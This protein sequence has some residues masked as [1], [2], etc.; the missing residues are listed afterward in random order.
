MHIIHILTN[1]HTQTHTHIY[2]IRIDNSNVY[3]VFLFQTSIS[4]MDV[5]A[6]CLTTSQ[7][8]LQRT[9]T[10]KPADQNKT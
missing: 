2:S 5:A 1:I 9:Y 4:L 8:D 3:F 10:L 7:Q 6:E